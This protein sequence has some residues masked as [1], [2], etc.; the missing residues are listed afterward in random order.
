MQNKEEA[1]WIYIPFNLK[2]NAFKVNAE[3]FYRHLVGVYPKFA[4]PIQI[5]NAKDLED[6]RREYLAFFKKGLNETSMQVLSTPK[7]PEG[8]LACDSNCHLSTCGPNCATQIL[9][10]ASCLYTGDFQIK[11]YSNIELDGIYNA[12][13][14]YNLGMIQVPHHCS[15][16]SFV[17]DFWD[18]IRSI[19]T[20]IISF[21][22]HG[23][24]YS[25]PYQPLVSLLQ[26]RGFK[27]VE[28]TDK[29][30]G[31]KVDVIRI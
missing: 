24:K 16:T 27:V 10:Y 19:N 26:S 22:S 6:I 2:S 3:N 15:K 30:P 31:L 14:Q 18:K 8:F 20:N 23:Y 28:V 29:S 9:R 1:E 17:R 5:T 7:S 4:S 12:L 13:Q 25:H 21:I 11:N